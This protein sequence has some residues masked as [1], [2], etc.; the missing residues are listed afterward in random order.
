[1]FDLKVPK[2]ISKIP[3][4]DFNNNDR[5]S[6]DSSIK[7]VL[8]ILG[9][10]SESRKTEMEDEINSIFDKYRTDGI[11]KRI[12]EDKINFVYK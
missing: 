2:G 8:Y 7:V 12:I 9:K 11:V 6:L 1:M 3:D 10:I 4:L 5:M